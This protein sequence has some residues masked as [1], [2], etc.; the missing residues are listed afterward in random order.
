MSGRHDVRALVT[1][2]ANAIGALVDGGL[3]R[4]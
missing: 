1:G 3:V 4:A 2:G